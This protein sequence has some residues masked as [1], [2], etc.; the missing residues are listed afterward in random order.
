MHASLQSNKLFFLWTESWSKIESIVGLKQMFIMRT[1]LSG[2]WNHLCWQ[3]S[4]ICTTDILSGVLTHRAFLIM[5][6]GMRPIARSII[7]R[8]SRL[9]W[10]YNSVA[11]CL[12]VM[13]RQ[14]LQKL[15]SGKNYTTMQRTQHKLLPETACSQCKVQTLCSQCSTRH[16][17]KTSPCLQ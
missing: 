5:W 16:M 9:S 11:T 6:L 3:P 13:S 14:T 12:S 15:Q 2:T 4:P 8:C 17:D 10:V 7:A 1:A